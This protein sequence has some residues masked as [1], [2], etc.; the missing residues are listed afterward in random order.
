M[1]AYERGS[2]A[3]IDPHLRSSPVTLA[4]VRVRI[5]RDFRDSLAL[6]IYV[7]VLRT[8]VCISAVGVVGY[9]TVVTLIAAQ[10]G[11]SHQTRY[12]WS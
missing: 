6:S 9:S 2:L 7:G 8:S 5:L 11:K 10:E 4:Q 1:S 3:L 12:L